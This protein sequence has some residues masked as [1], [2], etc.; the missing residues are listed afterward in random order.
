MDLIHFGNEEEL[1]IDRTTP[2]AVSGVST[3]GWRGSRSHPY[4]HPLELGIS[5][6]PLP[7]AA[8]NP[9]SLAAPQIYKLRLV[10]SP[11][12]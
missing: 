7:L 5:A 3:E 11:L 2:D 4:D 10:T 8:R 6:T 12:L 1:G 9:A